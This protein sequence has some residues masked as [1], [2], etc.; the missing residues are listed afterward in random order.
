MDLFGF[1]EFRGVV[2]RDVVANDG[3]VLGHNFVYRRLESEAILVRFEKITLFE[4]KLMNVT[5]GKI[6]V[7]TKN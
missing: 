7:E 5:T 1:E 2:L 3:W 4:I 6:H